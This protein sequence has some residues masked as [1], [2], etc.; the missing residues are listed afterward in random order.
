M[1][2]VYQVHN[3]L[4]ARVVAGGIQRPGGAL[5]QASWLYAPAPQHERALLQTVFG[6]IARWTPEDWDLGLAVFHRGQ[7]I[8]MQ[9][10]VSHDFGTTRCFGS[11][12]WLGLP[13]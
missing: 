7:P 3:S 1:A 12:C 11:G 5:F 4:L 9:H 13:Y 8:G 6:T 2:S 10:I